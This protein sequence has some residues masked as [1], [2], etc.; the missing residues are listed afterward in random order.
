MKKFYATCIVALFAATTLQAQQTKPLRGSSLGLSFMLFDFK[1]AE[2]IQ[3]SSLA[4]VR[5]NDQWTPLGQQSAG[6]GLHYVAGLTPHIDFVG[7]LAGAFTN[8]SLPSRP[9]TNSDFL[10]MEADASVN[11]KLLPENYIVTPFASLGAGV[12][13]YKSI[14]GAFMPVGGGLKFNAGGDTDVFLNFQYRVPVIKGTSAHHFVTGIG[15]SG[16]LGGD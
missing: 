6:V 12:S 5:A 15:V 8:F 1:T 10:L 9:K 13:T 4:T 2:L 3:K 14:W 7:T 11:F 16:L